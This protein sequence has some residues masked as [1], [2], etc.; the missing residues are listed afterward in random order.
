MRPRL[1]CRGVSAIETM[2]ALPML[3]MVGGGAL[4][5][6]LVLHAKHALNHALVEAARAG[7]VA[8]A[9]PVATREGLALGLMPWLF[10]AA[11]L[12]ESAVNRVRAIS[13]VA[14]AEARGELRLEQLSPTDASFADWAEPARDVTGERIPGVRE[15]PNDDLV[16]R[17]RRPPPGGASTADRR[18]EPIGAASGQTLADAN[19]LRLRLDYGV[20]LSVPVIGRVVAWS[21]RAWHGC[22]PVV[23][24]RFGPLDLGTP[25]GPGGPPWA[26]AML[27]S[28]TGSTGG[29]AR[30]PV[31]LSATVRMQSPARRSGGAGARAPDVD[32]R[33]LAGTRHPAR[34]AQSASGPVPTSERPA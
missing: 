34:G 15:I 6:G 18:G 27:G 31:T 17:L 20:P 25:R 3:M 8:H 10:G 19:L 14:Q 12:R 1:R 29:P 24:L 23:A 32:E 26:C 2:L 30:L 16:H 7:S 13:H 22:T 21:M 28:G 4:Q 9:D 11:D 33:P 5:F